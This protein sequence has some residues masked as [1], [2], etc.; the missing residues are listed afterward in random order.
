MARKLKVLGIALAAVFAMSVVATSAASATNFTAAAYPAVVSGTQT[1]TNI[2][3]ENGREFKCTTATFSGELTAA[4]ETFTVIKTT[5]SCSATVLGNV[6]PMTVTMNGCHTL[7]HVV[8]PG[9]TTI[10]YIC[11]FGQ[12]VE[13]HI[14]QNA[15]KHAEG[16]SLC[17]ITINAQTGLSQLG[18][19]AGTFEGKKDVTGSYNVKKIKYTVD[20]P[21]ITCGASGEAATYTGSV[22]FSAKKAGLPVDFDIG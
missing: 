12:K 5:A 16:V 19:A 13:T 3:T 14:Y 8:S 11:P 4:S 1:T 15:T 18:T 22:T 9:Q 21:A 6:L 2:F 20:G 10:D 17:T 7:Y